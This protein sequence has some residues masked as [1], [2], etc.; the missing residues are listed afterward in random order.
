MAFLGQR[1]DVPAL[2]RA[3]DIVVHSSVYP[4][5]FGR[6]VVEGMLAGKPVIAAN[7]GGVP[8]II[9]NDGTGVLVTPDDSAALAA[10]IARVIDDPGRAAAIGAA[11]SAHARRSFTREAMIEGVRSALATLG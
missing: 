11:G 8:E 3:A 9:I 7:A 10:A 2:L 4:E 6:V 5:P 1:D